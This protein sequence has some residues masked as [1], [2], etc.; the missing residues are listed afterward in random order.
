MVLWHHCLFVNLMVLIQQ[1]KIYCKNIHYDQVV[2]FGMTGRAVRHTLPNDALH[3]NKNKKITYSKLCRC[4][5]LIIILKS[6]PIPKAVII[7]PIV[8]IIYAVQAQLTQRDDFIIFGFELG[9][10][11]LLRH[12]TFEVSN[13]SVDKYHFV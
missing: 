2:K 9:I 1:K 7:I 13:E 8:C 5:L 10:D 6:R 11:L 12:N 4:V 3:L